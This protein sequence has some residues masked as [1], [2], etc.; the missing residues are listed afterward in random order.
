MQPSGLSTVAEEAVDGLW[1]NSSDVCLFGVTIYLPCGGGGKG[2]F[3]GV[4]EACGGGSAFAFDVVCNL[5]DLVEDVAV[6]VDE[7]GD[8]G[9]RV[10]DGGV[11]ASAEVAAYFGEGSVG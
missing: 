10:Y 5:V 1:I 6:V 11:V 4:G 7:F 2:V 9:G 8:L 3:R